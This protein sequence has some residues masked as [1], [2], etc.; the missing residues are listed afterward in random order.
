MLTTDVIIGT[1]TVNV[2]MADDFFRQHLEAIRCVSR[3]IY[4]QITPVMSSFAFT[5]TIRR[6]ERENFPYC[7]T[8]SIN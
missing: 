6:W 4:Q 2:T 1:R 5:L 7:T 3:L 8:S